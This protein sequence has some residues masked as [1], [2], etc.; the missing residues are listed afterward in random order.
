M[1]GSSLAVTFIGRCSTRAVHGTKIQ[2][3]LSN[4][5]SCNLMDMF[6]KETDNQN[7]I[8]RTTE[9]RYEVGPTEG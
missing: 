8:R 1:Q 4:P 2:P 6:E 5:T 7:F 9:F 3:T